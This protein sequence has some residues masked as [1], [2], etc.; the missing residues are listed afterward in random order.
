MDELEG[1][2]F[3][4]RCMMTINVERCDGTI[5]EDVDMIRKEKIVDDIESVYEREY[6]VEHDGEEIYLGDDKGNTIIVKERR[7]K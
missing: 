3:I 4:E 7:L 2:T 1:E 6:F 5:L